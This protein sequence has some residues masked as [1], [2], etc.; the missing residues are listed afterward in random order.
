[1]NRLRT[2][3]GPRIAIKALALGGAVVVATGIV[4][5]G[6]APVGAQSSGP[7]IGAKI[8]AYPSAASARQAWARL[9]SETSMALPKPVICP[10]MASGGL[11]YGLVFDAQS[12]GAAHALC[13]AAGRDGLSCSV[14]QDPCQN[15]VMALAGPISGPSAATPPVA[16]LA[17]AIA[18]SAP[19]TPAPPAAATA[20]LTTP[21]PLTATPPR[22][23]AGPRPDTATIGQS[24]PSGPDVS[25]RLAPTT[26]A[27]STPSRLPVVRSQSRPSSGRAEVIAT[28]PP[29]S[30]AAAAPISEP[31]L[32]EAPAPRPVAQVAPA[33]EPV[34][35]ATAPVAAPSEPS[36]VVA[37]LPPYSP[38]SGA[39]TQ[40]AAPIRQAPVAQAPRPVVVPAPTP[41]P[42]ITEPPITQEGQVIAVLP[43]STASP[44]LSSPAPA[45]APAPAP[46]PVQPSLSERL[47]A[48][49]STPPSVTVAQPQPP[50]APVQPST[51]PIPFVSAP[52]AEQVQPS[53]SATP[54]SVGQGPV[55]SLTQPRGEDPDVLPEAPQRTFP[56]AAPALPPELT[57]RSS[58]LR[59]ATDS[60][61][62][63][64]Y[65]KAV[66]LLQPL[67]RS[68]DPLAAFNLALLYANGFGVPRND[69][70]A[71]RLTKRA[72][73]QG[74][75]SAQNNLGLMHL[76]G[77]GTPRSL[78]LAARWLKKASESGHQR[79]RLNLLALVDNQLSEVPETGDGI[80]RAPPT[81]VEL[82]LAPETNVDPQAA[83]I[84]TVPDQIR[85]APGDNQISETP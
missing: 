41:A 44:S 40:P 65:D 42:V 20:P 72:A 3:R 85:A 52:P 70:E 78:T 5:S 43:P 25:A 47:Q 24:G 27:Q 58:V 34:Q 74:L 56:G 84:G 51:T 18:P 69:V 4:L 19:A 77:R 38:P 63:Q 60:V 35:Q 11:T 7:A 33:P 26:R 75:S 1:M 71:Y 61:R 37:V 16:A 17:P 46:A 54:P 82:G 76:Y 57:D 67:A 9:Q 59:A 83:D 53:V 22:L 50:Q 6:P 64:D 81:E 36:A 68:G 14:A 12:V 80:L 8:G 29:A 49:V 48:P 79:A 39:A 55:I 31:V 45:V 73:E 62:T 28:L 15:G 66:Q 30:A 21:P 2:K 32:I 13:G 23:V 10:S